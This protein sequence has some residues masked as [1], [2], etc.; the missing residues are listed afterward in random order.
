MQAVDGTRVGASGRAPTLQ[1][2]RNL[3]TILAHPADLPG[4]YANHEGVGFDVFIDHGTC[5]H[6]AVFTDGD[7]AHH[8]AVGP[9]RCAFFDEGIAVFVFAFYQSAGVV[10]VGEYH[11]GSAEDAFF[12]SDVVVNADVVLH[13]AAIANG[14]MVADEHVL[15]K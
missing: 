6:K 1:R 12:E 8:S 10:Y 9:K 14:D 2:K 11:A 5:A 4:G 15:A 3:F 13:F 7:A